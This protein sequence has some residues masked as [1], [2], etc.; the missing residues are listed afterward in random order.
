MSEPR[1]IFA[2]LGEREVHMCGDYVAVVW[3]LTSTDER[4]ETAGESVTRTTWRR[5]GKPYIDALF[6]RDM[7]DEHPWEEEDHPLKGGMSGSFARQ[8]ASELLAAADYL[9]SL[10][11]EA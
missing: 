4:H 8:I 1:R 9:A 11:E 2:R 10:K 3:N 6:V 7:D 5:N